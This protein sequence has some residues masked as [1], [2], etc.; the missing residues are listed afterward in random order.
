MFI[1][2][3][4]AQAGGGGGGSLLELLFP[5]ILV[6]GIMWFLVIRPQRQAAKAREEM[7]GAIRRS[8]TVITGGGIIGKVT[9]VID[10]AEL[11][12][13]IAPDVRVKIL[14]SLVADVRVKGQP[15]KDAKDKAAKVDDADDE[16]SDEALDATEKPAPKAKARRGT[17]TR[18]TASK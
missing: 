5:L 2:P 17:R 15:A 1:T 10:D 4:Y 18:K 12:I 14:R 7:L 13:Q 3:A 16:T 8:D 9:K 6:G 11:E